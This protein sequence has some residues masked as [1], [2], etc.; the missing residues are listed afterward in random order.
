V[1]ATLNVPTGPLAGESDALATIVL[2]G[3]GDS[4]EYRVAAFHNT[5][6]ASS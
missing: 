1:R 4:D 3:D 5:L 6:V 2:V